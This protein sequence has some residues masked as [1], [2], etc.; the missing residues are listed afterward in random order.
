MTEPP[1][2]SPSLP[3]DAPDVDAL[4][5]AEQVRALFERNTVA[6]ATVILN[7]LLVVVVL[8]GRASPVRI[9]AWLG[10]VWLLA[11]ARLAFGR[12]Y[13]RTRPGP[14]ELIPW[15]RRFTVGAALNGVAWGLTPLLLGGA[16]LESDLLFLAF[17]N[18]GMAAGSS[19]SNA[20]HQPAFVAFSLPALLPVSAALV[21]A[22]GRL[23]LGMAAMLA[24]YAA[25]V[26]AISRAG[27]RALVEATR[28]RFRNAQLADRLAA[29]AADLERRVAQRTG[30]LQAA[31]SREREVER[32]LT[33]S[34]RLASL[35]TL[36]ASVAHEVNSPLACVSSNLAFVR[37]EL[38]RE[39]GD[40]E[41][42]AAV[43]SALEDASAGLD[44]VKTIVRHLN[45]ASRVELRAD[46]GPVDVHAALEFSIAIAE[47][48]LR[49][50]AALVREYGEVPPVTAGH[51]HLIQVFLNLLLNASEAIP[52]GRPA[53]H[54]ICVTTRHEA[55]SGQVVVEVA[56][57][58]CGIPAA[59]LDRIWE[60]SFAARP[61][62]GSGLGLAMCRDL[63]A[64]CGG[65]IGVRSVEGAGS[66]FTVWLRPAPP[67]SA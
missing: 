47:G 10:V 39:V 20:S 35:G 22:G 48:D 24:I 59:Q 11:G 53:D 7:S 44:R 36:A 18:G 31:V 46:L 30:E 1:P 9:L 32:Q 43:R 19:L 3:D 27:G 2:R 61:G 40:P 16:A 55:A 41:L 5:D 25:A 15:R 66:T 63:L 26:T 45:D 67:A 58:G 54:R 64:R 51:M 38:E 29:S 12:A 62:P 65:R 50:R 49:S 52:A 56:D 21:V 57:T 13:A 17:V 8:W 4:V 33:N 14:R 60:P 6:Q 23:H 34:I 37:E 28:L 42:R